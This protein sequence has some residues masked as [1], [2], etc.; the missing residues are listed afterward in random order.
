MVLRK[1]YILGQI[2]SY[3][4]KIK[5]DLKIENIQIDIMVEF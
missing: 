4:S 3:K 5:L 2:Q 1:Y